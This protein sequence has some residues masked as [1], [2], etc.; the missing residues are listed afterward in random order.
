MAAGDLT[1]WERL[2]RVIRHVHNRQVRKFF[3]S[4]GSG[5]GIA[6]GRKAILRDLLLMNDD[7]SALVVLNKQMFFNQT[8]QGS[9]GG[10]LA[11]PDWWYVSPGADRPMLVIRFQ[12]ENKHRSSYSLSIPHYNGAKSPN[13]PTFNKGEHWGMLTLTDGSKLRV[14]ASSRAECKRVINALDNYIIPRFKQGRKP[15]YGE[16]GV[17]INR[18]KVSPVRADYYPDGPTKPSAWREYF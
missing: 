15:S 7:D 9:S 2:Q 3:T 12:A 14:Y 4:D 17:S 13:I 11:L 16:T 8:V 1:E 6:N 18:V 5:S 10:D